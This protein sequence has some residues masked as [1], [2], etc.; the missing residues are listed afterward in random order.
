MLEFFLNEENKI[1]QQGY[2]ISCAGFPAVLVLVFVNAI[3]ST[4]KIQ[5]MV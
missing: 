2:I 4:V 5:N 3:Y 1:M